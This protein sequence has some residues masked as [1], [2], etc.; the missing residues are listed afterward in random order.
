MPMHNL[1]P[2]RNPIHRVWQSI[3]EFFSSEKVLL[4]QMEI[5]QAI[6]GT[7]S[8]GPSYHFILD[9]SDVNRPTYLSPSIEELLGLDPGISSID[10]IVNRVH[11]DDL[12]FV[13]EAEETAIRLLNDDTRKK[14]IKSYKISYCFRLKTRTG[15]YRLFHHQC[16]ILATDENHGAAAALLIHTDISHLTAT[17]NYKLS[18]LHLRGGESSMNIN[19]YS[20]NKK[21]SGALSIFTTREV[22]VLQLLTHGQTSAQIAQQLCISENTVKNHRKSLLK[23]AHCKTTGQLVSK[24]VTEKFN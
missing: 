17:N 16:V 7:F 13:T 9:F 1:Q 21:F 22:E 4:S 20:G 10:D 14:D 15:D 11:P 24:Y 3:P 23:K 18:L 12:P 8:S 19:V 5:D 6:A 2:E